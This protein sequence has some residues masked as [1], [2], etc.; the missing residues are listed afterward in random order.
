MRN[1]TITLAAVLLL[2]AAGC[3]G[4]KELLAQKDAEI[5]TLQ[6]DKS[7]LQNDLDQQKK[8]NDDLNSQLADLTSQK[9]V[10]MEQKDGLT[11]ITL[12]GAATFA[13]AQADLTAEG[14]DVIDRVW[15]VLQNYPD[16]YILI[17][18]HTDNQPIKPSYRH[19]YA[20]NWELSSARSLAVLH[21]VEKK[22]NPDANRLAAV[23]YGENEPVADNSTV[24]GRAQ[25]RRVVITVG[26]KMAVQQ[27]MKDTQVNASTAYPGGAQMD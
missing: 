17:E 6:A 15:G 26:S 1:P 4:N 3:S 12:D 20:S 22:F 9:R 7:K 5:A 18:G 14:K 23:G 27:R 24:E 2:T 25:N 11:Y 16:R 8:M 10:L 19:V 21:Y 13:S